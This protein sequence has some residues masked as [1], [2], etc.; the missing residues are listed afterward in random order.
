MIFE[1]RRKTF[2]THVALT[3][4]HIVS[5]IVWQLVILAYFPNR[6]CMDSTP[7]DKREKLQVNVNLKDI[8]SKKKSGL[9]CA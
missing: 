3:M 8:F 7:V 2:I 6:F 4:P 5:R 9:T 1:L